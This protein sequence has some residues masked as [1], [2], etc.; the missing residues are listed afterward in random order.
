VV[1]LGRSVVPPQSFWGR[2]PPATA[3]T[4]G[5]PLPQWL[6]V[7]SAAVVIGAP[8]SLVLGLLASVLVLIYL[9]IVLAVLTP[10]ALA[11]LIVGL[12]QRT[13]R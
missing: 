2:L 5:T 8:V 12:I 7:V 13:R 9:S 6:L 3:V 1:G 4:P 11:V 10:F